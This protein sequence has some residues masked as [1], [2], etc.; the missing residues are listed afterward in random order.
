MQIV[1]M[2]DRSQGKLFTTPEMYELFRKWE[3]MSPQDKNIYRFWS[4]AHPNLSMANI[5]Y[6][7]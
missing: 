1:A 6:S 7:S 2:A 5:T 3:Y 4:R